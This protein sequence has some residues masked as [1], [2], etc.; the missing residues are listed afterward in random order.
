[1]DSGAR[2]GSNLTLSL[3]ICVN[4]GKLLHL[5]GPQLSYLQKVGAGGGNTSGDCCEDE[6]R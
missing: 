6:M 1:M 2:L 4:L 3:G 5:P